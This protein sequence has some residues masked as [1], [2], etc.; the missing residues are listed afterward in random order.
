MLSLIFPILSIPLIS[1]LKPTSSW[2]T[3]ATSLF[4]L[5]FLSLIFIPTDSSSLLIGHR[6]IIIDSLSLPLISLTL[7]ISGLIVLASF[8]I[9]ILKDRP[10]LLLI[11]ITILASVLSVFFIASHFITFYVIFEAALI[12]TVFLILMWG[13]QPERLQAS[14]Y[15]ILYTV[16]ASLPFLIR[17]LLILRKNHSLFIFM[18]LWDSPVNN[19][20]L[21]V[22]WIFTIGAFLV[23]IPIFTLHLWLPKA[24][25]EAPL[26]GSIILAAILLKLGSYGLIR[27]RRIFPH[28]NLLIFNPITSLCILGACVTGAICIR[29]TDLKAL[30]AYSSVGHIGL[31]TA[32]VLSSTKWGWEGALVIIIAHGLSSSALFCV[33]NSSYEATHTRRLFLTKGL[34]ALF[35]AM[36]LWWFLACAANISAPPSINLLREILLL[37]AI[38]ANSIWLSLGLVVATLL[39]GAY[40]LILFSSTQHGHP[41]NLLISLPSSRPRNY[42]LIFLH[43]LPIFSLIL[44]SNF[45]SSWLL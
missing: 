11:N 22:W 4:F 32:A 3:T 19:Q 14:I 43:I 40:S 27:L 24:H 28:F 31:L 23:K 39:S 8:R 44:T 41:S 18:S 21:T 42:L 17:L 10:S 16:T 12:P 38:L 33:A 36:S 9:L 5:T 26:A 1:F 35:P 2:A 29:Q 45:I 34:L 15:L 20:I 30:I 6:N 25:V 13:A 7:W 37:P